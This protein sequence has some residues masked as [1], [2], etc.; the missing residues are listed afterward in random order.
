MKRHDLR[1][2]DDLVAYIAANHE[3]FE[4]LAAEYRRGGLPAASMNPTSR[5]S[6]EPQ[7]PEWDAADRQLNGRARLIEGALRTALQQLEMA[8]RGI[9]WFITPTKRIEDPDPKS[10]ANARCPD[11]RVFSMIGRDRP[12]DAD[13]RCDACRKFHGRHQR[14]RTRYAAVMADD[15][16][17]LSE[18]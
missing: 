15:A 3:H 10:C 9:R 6:G 5:S 7:P 11:A 18:E 14:E 1:R 8:E 17:K 16:T 4:Q 12:Q 13:G 2:M